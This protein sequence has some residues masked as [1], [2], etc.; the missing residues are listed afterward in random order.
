MSVVRRTQP[1]A[2]LVLAVLLV[3]LAL[4]AC[5]MGPRGWPGIATL[6]NGT[7]FVGDLGG[8]LLSFNSEGRREWKWAPET[9]ESSNP[10]LSC[11]T[12]GGGTGQ[13]R[14]GLF[15]GPPMVADEVVY[16]GSY[17]GTIYAIDAK[18]GDQIWSYDL[19]KPVIGG[20]AVSGGTL[21]VGDSDG[22]MYAID[23][24]SGL[25]KPGFIPFETKDKI[26]SAPAVSDGT[27]YFGSLDHNLYA[28]DADTGEPKWAEPFKTG[29]GIGATP[30]VVDDLVLIGSFDDKFYAVDSA[31]G[32]EKWVFEGATDWFWAQP[33]VDDG[34]IYVPS[35]DGKVYA[36]DLQTGEQ[37]SVWPA[38]FDAKDLLKAS[39]TISGD[40]LAVATEKGVVIGIDLAT[41]EEKWSA[42]LESK[43]FAPLVSVGGTVFVNAQD[44]RLYALDGATGNENW[45]VG[46]GD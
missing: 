22:K 17:T 37:A 14:A 7:L 42:D 13:F 38:P 40:V 5:S 23:V 32:E 43:I 39:P 6:G 34:T 20:V 21:Y 9:E 35:F 8:E 45:S 26:W 36:L 28:I 1:I 18:N 11:G 24:A 30:V 33:V 2:L 29:G 41:G 10:L 46:L 19:D 16:V 31:T 3:T 44:N 15:Y 12:S 27:V 25:P 4:S